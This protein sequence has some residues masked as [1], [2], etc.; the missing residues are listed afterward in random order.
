[1]VPRLAGTRTIRHNR[2]LPH[3]QSWLHAV[4]A[5]RLELLVAAAL[6]GLR[7]VDLFLWR[8]FIRDT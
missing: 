6:P 8:R 4:F 2:R 7:T 5:E 3:A 1:M